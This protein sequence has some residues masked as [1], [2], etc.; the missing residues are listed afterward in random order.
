MSIT[1]G[2]EATR[3]RLSPRRAAT[4]DRLAAAVLDELGG[5]AGYADLTVRSVARRAGVA[6]ATAYTYFT[7]KAHLVAE[8][9]WRRLA[10]LPDRPAD[11]G[12]TAAARAAA[13]LGDVAELVAGEPRL[14][15]AC[16]PALLG[17]D[18]DVAVLRDRI[19]AELHRRLLAALV[20]DPDAEAL[21]T[22]LDL[23]LAGALVR[24]GIGHMPYDELATRLAAL[25]ALVVGDRP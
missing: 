20:P 4:V 25:A 12:R 21:A 15:A 8:V 16:A 10:A 11:P 17:D 14:A 1:A 23:M 18:P 22:A 9:F 24:A 5:R 6:P 7:S 3:R 19:G 13:V 2:P